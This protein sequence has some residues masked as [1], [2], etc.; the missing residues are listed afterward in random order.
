MPDR[1]PLPVIAGPTASGKTGLAIYLAQKFHG[2][3]VSAD[4][5]Q[6]YR[7]VSI[8][9]ARPSTEEM[10]GVPHHMMGFCPLEEKYSVARYVEEAAAVIREIAARG[11]PPILCGGTGLYIQSLVEN[12]QFMP[13]KSNPQLR[14]ML[15]L[16]GRNEGGDVLLGELAAIDPETAARLHPHDMGRIVRALELYETTGVTM[17]EQLRR[18]R[19][20]PSP[21]DTCLLV[22]DAHDRNYLYERINRRT[23]LMLR[24]GLLE[25]AE[26]VLRLSPEA[27]AVQAIGYKELLPYFAHALP[28]EKAAENLKRQTRRYAKRQL[29]WFRRMR[30]VQFLFIDETGQEDLYQQAAQRIAAHYGWQI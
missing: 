25:E 11:K 10:A 20:Q 8:G 15:L 24:Q 26:R 18:S 29:S 12:L 1:V 23:D 3:V 22:L 14:E 7:D 27:T 16:R 9:T 2:E 17:S 21:Y 30:D 13:E 19:L 28:L 4:S 5:M 6:I